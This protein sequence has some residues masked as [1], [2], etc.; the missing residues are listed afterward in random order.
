MCNGCGGIFHYSKLTRT[1]KEIR[2]Y[3]YI[4]IFPRNDCWQ[5]WEPESEF[6]YDMLSNEKFISN[7][8]IVWIG[9]NFS[10]QSI[11]NETCIKR[12]KEIGETWNFGL[13]LLYLFEDFVA[14]SSFWDRC[15]LG[16][17]MCDIWKKLPNV[18]NY[19]W[20]LY[21]CDK[22]TAMLFYQEIYDKYPYLSHMWL[23]SKDMKEEWLIDELDEN[24]KYS[25]STWIYD[26]IKKQ[27]NK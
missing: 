23:H 14:V 15:D 18:N 4:N 25:V 9:G 13:T 19:D 2:G 24:E 6:I 3:D 1:L 20:G 16:G 8:D 12:I 17:E 7:D 22:Q 27:I 21:K 10:W 5:N 26:D 11:T